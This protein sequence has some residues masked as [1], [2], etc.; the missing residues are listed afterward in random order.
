MRRGA[1]ESTRSV[2]PAAHAT[3]SIDTAVSAGARSA[4]GDV[5]RELVR[6]V[7]AGALDRAPPRR[8]WH[9]GRRTP[10]P[11]RATRAGVDRRRRRSESRGGAPSRSST[12][13]S[14]STSGASTKSP[15]S[16]ATKQRPAG[17]SARSRDGARTSRIRAREHRRGAV[18]GPDDARAGCLEDRVRAFLDPQMPERFRRRLRPRR[19]RREHT[20]HRTRREPHPAQASTDARTARTHSELHSYAVRGTDSGTTRCDPRAIPARRFLRRPCHVQVPNPSHSPARVRLDGVRSRPR[21]RSMCGVAE[22][23]QPARDRWNAEFDGGVRRRDWSCSLR[24]WRFPERRRRGRESRR[25]VERFGLVRSRKR[26]QRDREL[27]RRVRR[28]SRSATLR[29]RGLRISGRS[30]CV[31]SRQV[32]RLDLV[33]RRR[34]ALRGPRSDRCA[35][36][37][38]ERVQL[39]TSQETSPSPAHRVPGGS[40]DGTA[41]AGHPWAAA[42]PA[43]STRGSSR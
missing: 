21:A 22:R 40:R 26:R 28:R 27:A 43:A 10:G 42:S 24:R 9:R 3:P 25:Q 36:S 15:R 2:C 8:S 7:V 34:L 33:G 18:A 30:Q 41:R 37:T 5:V 14:A 6:G 19:E 4:S 32:E 35:C 39:S 23:I 1:S 16:A 31:Q 20:Q 29:R 13:S 17:S 38:T 12:R 11:S